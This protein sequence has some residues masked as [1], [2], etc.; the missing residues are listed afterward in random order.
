M[1]ALDPQDGAGIAERALRAST[2]DECHVL[3]ESTSQVNQRWARN[4]LTTNG[5]SLSATVTVVAMHHAQAGVATA[6]VSRSV[7]SVDELTALV[8]DVGALAAQAPVAPDA[9]E[10]RYDGVDQEFSDRAVPVV[11]EGLSGTVADLGDFLSWSSSSDIETFGYLEK[12][13]STRWL[14]TSAGA[15]RRFT[16]PA[17]RFEVTAKSHDRQRSTWHGSAD[18]VL[19]QEFWAR[20]RSGVARELT[21]QGMPFEVRPG[22]HDVVLPPGAIGDLM[23]DL[24]WAAGARDA[25][26]GRTAF[27]EAPAGT[28]IGQQVADR[29]IA[30][31]SDPADPLMPAQPFAAT[32]FSSRQASVFDNGMDLHRTEWI[33]G[34]TLQHL[35]TTGFDASELGVQN[36]PLIDNI[37]LDASPDAASL[38]E[39]VGRTQTGLLLTCVWYNR[40][41]DPQR[42]LLTGLTRDGVYVIRDGEIVGACGNMRFNDS[43]LSMLN[44]VIA[45]SPSVRTLP[46][47]MADYANRVTMPAISVEG[48]HF[49]SASEAR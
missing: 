22:R 1:T 13:S 40:M 4:S 5:L 26:E 10:A 11:P 16:Q 28:R 34:G 44:R 27:H 23:V 9:T 46:R 3:V 21:W 31:S 33:Q 24:L 12:A 15:R 38:E 32:G 41:V 45:A 36:T 47:E 48:M 35:H 39:L 25:V 2:A 6:S 8:H 30:L 17:D 43:P 19:G 20:L 18:P 29:R 49:T 14:A 7:A 42:M 37:R